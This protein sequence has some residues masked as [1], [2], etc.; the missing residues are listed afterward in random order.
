M[1]TKVDLA[2][3]LGEGLDSEMNY[4]FLEQEHYWRSMKFRIHMTA[5][6]FLLDAKSQAH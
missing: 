1:V 4:K 5:R 2:L 3:Y 6:E